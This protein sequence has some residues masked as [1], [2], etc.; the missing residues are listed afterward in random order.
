MWA[1]TF[2]T[3]VYDS[4]PIAA[5]TTIANAIAY[6]FTFNA[7][8]KSK[9]LVLK[10]LKYD[11]FSG[12]AIIPNSRFSKYVKKHSIHIFPISNIDKQAKNIEMQNAIIPNELIYDDGF[13]NTS[14]KPNGLKFLIWILYSLS[15]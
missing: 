14:T 8:I 1:R 9:K 15:V 10:I 5:K 3:V 4:T 6:F 11:S 7:D 2:D 13:L 12:F